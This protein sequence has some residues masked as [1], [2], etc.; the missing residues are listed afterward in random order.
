MATMV[1][2]YETH[3]AAHYSWLLGGLDRK[4]RENKAFF[5][6]HD[7]QPLVDGRAVDLGC[8]SGFQ[9][10]PLAELGFEVV[11]VPYEAVV[12]FGGLLH[13]TTLDVYREGTC[14][15]YF[16]KQVPGY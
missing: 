16:P 13:C 10:I 9:A 12:P 11:E 15:D 6:L 8:G 3:L 1:E 5:F 4:C 14:E 7:I 2:H